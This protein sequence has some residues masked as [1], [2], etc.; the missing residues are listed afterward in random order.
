MAKE[1][2][3]H[4]NNSYSI[5][6]SAAIVAILPDEYSKKKIPNQI[7]FTTI[8][9]V[10]STLSENPSFKPNPRIEIQIKLCH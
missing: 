3:H 5:Y 10:S 2:T 6:S 8:P 1:Y 9:Q 7:V 4:W